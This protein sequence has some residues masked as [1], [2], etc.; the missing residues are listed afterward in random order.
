LL[1]VSAALLT[2]GPQMMERIGIGVE[3]GRRVH[4]HVAAECFAGRAGE[5]GVEEFQDIA[6]DPI[7]AGGVACHDADVTIE[8]FEFDLDAWLQ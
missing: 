4:A 1:I 2:F 5:S 3:A 8:V 6:A 7:M